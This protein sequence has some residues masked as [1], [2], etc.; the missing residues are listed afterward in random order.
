MR[1]EYGTPQLNSTGLYESRVAVKFCGTAE[2][3]RLQDVLFVG[4]SANI[5]INGPRLA[6]KRGRTLRYLEA[7][8]LWHFNSGFE[9]CDVF[10][11]NIVKKVNA[12]LN[13]ISMCVTCYNSKTRN[14]L[15]STPR[16]TSCPSGLSRDG[17]PAWFRAHHRQVLHELSANATG[18][19]MFN[20]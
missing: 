8:S 10:T 4:L 5:V 2:L 1:I 16:S 13:P 17:R 11:T 12:A 18:A 20:R 6:R 7:L 14:K 9:I 15:E 19:Q 3:F